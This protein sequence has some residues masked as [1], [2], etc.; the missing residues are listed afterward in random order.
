MRRRGHGRIPDACKYRR[1][2][3]RR[4]MLCVTCRT[5]RPAFIPLPYVPEGLR[6]PF[7]PLAVI[8]VADFG[9][10]RSRLVTLNS[11]SMVARGFCADCGTP[12]IFHNTKRGINETAPRPYTGHHTVG[13]LSA[14]RV[15][16]SL[17]RGVFRHHRASTCH[18]AFK[19]FLPYTVAD[20][21]NGRRPSN[22][23]GDAEFRR[24]GQHRRLRPVVIRPF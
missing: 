9:W 4:R 20:H 6:G 21:P 19:L 11:S 12:L 13:T 22:T 3:M 23:R 16:W 15:G 2:L 14:C 18:T 17:R 24:A 1:L 10:T 7:G 8:G 5:I